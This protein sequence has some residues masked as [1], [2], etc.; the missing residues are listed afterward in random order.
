MK[1]EQAGGA[2]V[3]ESGDHQDGENL[4]GYDCFAYARD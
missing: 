4:F 3:A 2:D 1:V